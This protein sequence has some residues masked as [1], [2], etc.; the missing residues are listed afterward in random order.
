ML[1]LL[2]IHLNLD[3]IYEASKDKESETKRSTND[4]LVPPP[5]AEIAILFDLAMKGELPRLRKR[6]TKIA[7]MDDKYKPFA[8]KLSQLVDT[9]DEDQILELIEQYRDDST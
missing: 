1:A 9:F 3:W 5:P 8:A 6:V 4:L 2:K 7:K